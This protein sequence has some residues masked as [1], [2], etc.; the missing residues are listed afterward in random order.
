MLFFTCSPEHTILLLFTGVNN[1][2]TNNFGMA[3]SQNNL[4]TLINIIKQMS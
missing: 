1:E 2:D 4:P 3:S